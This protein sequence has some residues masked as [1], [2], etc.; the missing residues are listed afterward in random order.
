MATTTWGKKFQPSLTFVA[1][2]PTIRVEQIIS[3]LIYSLEGEDRVLGVGYQLP[4]KKD[5]YDK[6]KD[7]QTK[8]KI[9]RLPGT[10]K[11]RKTNTWIDW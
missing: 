9:N 5:L 10:P 11:A 3:V 1:G 6:K 4:M 8:V 2:H 7:R